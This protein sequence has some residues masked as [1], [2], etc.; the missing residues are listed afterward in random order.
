[1]PKDYEKRRDQLVRQGKPL[2]QAKT[3]TRRRVDGKDTLG[4]G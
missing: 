2:K 4:A 1:M 3:G